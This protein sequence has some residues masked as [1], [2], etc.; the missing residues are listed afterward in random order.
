VSITVLTSAGFFDVMQQLVLDGIAVLG[1]GH[2]AFAQFAGSTLLSAILDNTI[3][4]DF[5]SRGLHGLDGRTVHFFAMAQIAGYALGGS[6]RHIRWVALEL[7]L[8][9]TQ[10]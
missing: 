3:V 4:A 2:V 9:V 1:Q 7:A 8:A 10:R 6:W 5:A